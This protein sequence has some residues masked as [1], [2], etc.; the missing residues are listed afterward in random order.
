MSPTAGECSG[1]QE[2]L[3]EGHGSIPSSEFTVACFAAVNQSCSFPLREGRIDI[4][5]QVI[6]QCKLNL[7]R[8]IG[9]GKVLLFKNFLLKQ[10]NSCLNDNND[11]N[12]NYNSNNSNSNNNPTQPLGITTTPEGY[13]AEK[14]VFAAAG[15]AT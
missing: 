11:N 10:N 13:I 9:I 3:G 14:V 5:T 12:D 4:Q 2:L 1:C 7:P 8:C 6:G 15:E